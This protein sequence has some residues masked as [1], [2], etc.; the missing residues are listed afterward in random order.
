MRVCRFSGSIS[1]STNLTA[2]SNIAALHCCNSNPLP[3]LRLRSVPCQFNL[4][5]DTRDLQC[6]H[7]TLPSIVLPIPDLTCKNWHSNGAISLRLRSCAGKLLNQIRC[8]G[9]D[10]DEQD[11]A[12]VEG[13][14]GNDNEMECDV[15]HAMADSSFSFFFFFFPSSFFPLQ[16]WIS[17][18]QTSVWTLRTISKP[19]CRPGAQLGPQFC[20]C[21]IFL[22]LI[23]YGFSF[24]GFSEAMSLCHF[25]FTAREKVSGSR[26]YIVITFEI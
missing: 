11:V 7:F 1:A 22:K 5:T 18:A 4:A 10:C 17:Q 6:M 14:E 9:C 26:L 15:K 20:W 24:L 12:E 13:I 16:D 25:I 3:I 23:F 21:H 2:G 19:P 8:S